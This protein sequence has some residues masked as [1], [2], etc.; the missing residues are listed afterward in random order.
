MTGI[1]RQG[2][3]TR[4]AAPAARRWTACVWGATALP[5]VRGAEDGKKNASCPQPLIRLAVQDLASRL[6]HRVL[7]SDRVDLRN[8]AAMMYS[9]VKLHTPEGQDELNRA[10]T[11]A[12]LAKPE[13][14]TESGVAQIL[15]AYAERNWALDPAVAAKCVSSRPPVLW[16][17][18]PVFA[19]P[20]MHP[21]LPCWLSTCVQGGLRPTFFLLLP[22]YRRLHEFLLQAVPAFHFPNSIARVSG[23]LADMNWRSKNVSKNVWAL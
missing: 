22:R 10:L 6:I 11:A 2:R 17:A 18:S 5:P 3:Q 1:S 14:L 8:L 23:A 4:R 19:R 15:M 9:S 21:L 20:Q 16:G 12:I 7:K 13:E